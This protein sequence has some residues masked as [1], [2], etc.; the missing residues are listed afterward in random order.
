MHRKFLS[1]A[2]K[3]KQVEEKK[4]RETANLTKIPKINQV[5]SAVPSTSCSTSTSISNDA[6]DEVVR[7]VDSAI[8]VAASDVE[9]VGSDQFIDL[10]ANADIVNV[11]AEEE[12]TQFPEDV[13]LWNVEADITLLQKYWIEKG[14]TSNYTVE[15]YN[16]DRDT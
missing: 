3:R 12:F 11:S 1:G 7:E 14:I 4:A 8:N 16:W 6:D 5:F 2:Q 9:H 13:A 15:F 10:D